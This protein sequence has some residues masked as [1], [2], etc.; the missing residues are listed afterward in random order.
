MQQG[1]NVDTKTPDTAGE[2]P[3]FQEVYGE[4]KCPGSEA[5][6]FKKIIEAVLHAL[7]S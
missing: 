5:A 1:T 6:T 4:I 7:T 2:P 3:T